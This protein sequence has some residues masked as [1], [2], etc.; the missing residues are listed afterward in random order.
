[1]SVKNIRLAS[2]LSFDA[3]Q[4]ADIINI[5]ESFNSS[6]KM[7]AFMSS[8]IRI[9][10][11]NP[12]IVVSKNGSYES[13]ELIKVIERLGKTP[14]RYNYMNE[15]N[16]KLLDMQS[17]VDSMYEMCLKMYTMLELGKRLGVQQKTENMLLAQ[18]SVEQQLEQ[19]KKALGADCRNIPFA[20]NRLINADKRA[21]DTLEYIISCYEPIINELKKELNVT[22][23]T[24]EIPVVKVNEIE[25]Q[26]VKQTNTQD[27]TVS[28][29]SKPKLSDAA[30]LDD[31]EDTEIDFDTNADMGALLDFFN[32]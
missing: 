2:T 9:A 19:L 27:N 14:T 3:E 12:E 21:A 8:L 29:T 16:K 1:M 18:F 20:S 24:I 10:F 30:I 31:T 7:G 5:I 17:K 11:E 23:K 22:T 4:E 15:V 13:G 25:L 6:H 32:D 26:A 28:D